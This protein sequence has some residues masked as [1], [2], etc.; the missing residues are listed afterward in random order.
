MGTPLTPQSEQV[1]NYILPPA[2]QRM[3]TGFVAMDFTTIKDYDV[4]YSYADNLG[5]DLIIQSCTVDNTGN[6]ASI[7]LAFDRT[8]KYTRTIKAG[9]L[10]VFNVPATQPSY[11]R[12]TST[13]TGK[14]AA[15]FH[16]FPSLPDLQLP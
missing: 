9:E 1:L 16:N 2:S 12:I 6:N 4:D 11:V 8:L 10:R 13:G 14:A 5:N 7:V 15:F 3:R